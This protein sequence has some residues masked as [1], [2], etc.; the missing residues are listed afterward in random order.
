MESRYTTLQT[1]SRI[2]KEQPNQIQYLTNPRELILHSTFD[3]ELI[4]IHLT[5][6][7]KEG[8]VKITQADTLL[9]SITV[10]GMEMLSTMTT[11]PE[12][13]LKISLRSEDITNENTLL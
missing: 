8:F 3:W 4:H 2:A 6:L 7:E 13:Q 12:T 9:F 1:L 10:A 11:Q 5:T